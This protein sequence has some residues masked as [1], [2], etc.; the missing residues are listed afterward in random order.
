MKA[1]NDD[2]FSSIENRLTRLETSMDATRA[3]VIEM[4]LDVKD[5]KRDVTGLVMSMNSLRVTQENHGVRLS[6]VEERNR[7]MDKM[8]GGVIGTIIIAAI[9]GAV[10]LG[11]A[12][13]VHEAQSTTTI[14]SVQVDKTQP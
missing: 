8:I 13:K 7:G 4:G 11:V 5:I 6:N 10:A 1:M 2:R 12:F 9:L 3:D 14:E